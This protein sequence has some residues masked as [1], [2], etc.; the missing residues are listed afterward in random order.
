MMASSSLS[1]RGANNINTGRASFKENHHRHTTPKV[2][3]S[4][5][6]TYDTLQIMSTEEQEE[7]ERQHDAKMDAL[8]KIS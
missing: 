1:R 7:A 6:R 2:T 5:R 8:P 4:D 3:R